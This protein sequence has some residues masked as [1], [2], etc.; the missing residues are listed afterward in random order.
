MISTD[1]SSGSGGE[2]PASCAPGSI[3]L[4][5]SWVP[6]LPCWLLLCRGRGLVC[7]LF[8]LAPMSWLCSAVPLPGAGVSERRDRFSGG[9]VGDLGTQQSWGLLSSAL[10]VSFPLCCPVF[11]GGRGR[12]TVQGEG[13]MPKG[14]EGSL[15][16]STAPGSCT[17]PPSPHG[18]GCPTSTPPAGAGE[19]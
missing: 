4:R 10:P 2:F 12:M 18:H 3:C 13:G 5:Q 7:C 17:P 8:S 11:G 19:P 15:V 9:L 1:P 14:P 16:A 6:P